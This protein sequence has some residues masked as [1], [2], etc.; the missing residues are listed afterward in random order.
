MA[1][2]HIATPHDGEW[3]RPLWANIVHAGSGPHA[4]SRFTPRSFYTLQRAGTCH[5]CPLKIAHSG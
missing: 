3:N 5:H 1:K 2:G 4:Y